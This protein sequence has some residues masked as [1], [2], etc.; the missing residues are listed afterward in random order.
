MTSPLFSIE[1]NLPS[2]P[3]FLFS[4]LRQYEH[5]FSSLH[6]IIMSASPLSKK[7]EEEEEDES[8]GLSSSFL[9]RRV[10]S[11]SDQEASMMDLLQPVM[12][13]QK[14]L[15]ESGEFYAD[16]AFGNP[17][18]PPV[19]GFV[20]TL[21]QEAS[22]GCSSSPGCSP[23]LF[24]HQW[25][26]PEAKQA[27]LESLQRRRRRHGSSISS[28][29]FTN[30]D[31]LTLDHIFV[32]N[33]T[34]GSVM[35]AMKTFSNVGDVLV[36]VLPEYIGYQ[37]MIR[38]LECTTVKIPLSPGDNFELH[39]APIQ[40]MLLDHP[41]RDRMRILLLT[42]PNNPSGQ[43]YSEQTLQEL[44]DALHHVN[45]IRSTK[46]LPPIIVISDE[47]SHRIVFPSTN[48][49]FLSPASFYEY[50]VSTYS[51][52]KTCM[53]PSEPLGWLVL[54]PLWP[55]DKLALTQRALMVAQSSTG[56]LAPSATHARC[57]P[58]LEEEIGQQ[59]H[60]DDHHN[61]GVHVDLHLLE[62]RRDQFVSTLTSHGI[63]LVFPQVINPLSGC[64]ILLR[65]PD[66]F[67]PHRDVDFCNLLAE[68]YRVVS[69]PG[70]ILG[71]PGWIRWS[72]TASQD[73]INLTC[74]QIHAF[75]LDY[76]SNDP[77][78]DPWL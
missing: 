46:H 23:S 7:E 50:T 17:H 10:P 45:E 40:N 78:L 4:T 59:Q 20:T 35:M 39:V 9:S 57:I 56:W 69:M 64:Y 21:R 44:A 33:G 49:P 34:F 48:R 24:Q 36:T 22:R 58:A 37:D 30:Y 42:C 38:G 55:R 52:A 31:A 54:S 6:I 28:S 60:K 51:Y 19:E 76:E 68:K 41:Q 67:Y 3:L 26:F 71:L 16:L 1:V 61:D 8:S 25:E 72:I 27:I 70:S 18:D 66:A 62:Q 13:H 29:S 2:S 43:V 11:S 65:V 73:M 32:T 53:A 75:V 74:Q 14:R 15:H 12:M 77:T 47:A 5:F 63:H